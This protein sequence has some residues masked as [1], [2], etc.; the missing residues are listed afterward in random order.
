M[1]PYFL[2]VSS[3]LGTNSSSSSPSSLIPLKRNEIVFKAVATFWD[4]AIDRLRKIFNKESEEKQDKKD[5][6][7]RIIENEQKIMLDFDTDN[8]YNDFGCT[9]SYIRLNLS[10]FEVGKTHIFNYSGDSECMWCGGSIYCDYDEEDK[11]V[12]RFIY[13]EEGYEF[14]FLV[15]V[16]DEKDTNWYRCC[17]IIEEG[18]DE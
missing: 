15:F 10:K 18:E 6:A 13:Y 3:I 14:P 12:G 4:W 7:K 16:E 11:L 1:S 2:K 8:M 9:T 17:E 5:I